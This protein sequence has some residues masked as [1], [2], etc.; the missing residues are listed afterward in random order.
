MADELALSLAQAIAVAN[1]RAGEAGTDV[2]QSLITITQRFDDDGL[3]W[4]INYGPRE[5]LNRRG[6]DLIVD[7]DTRDWTVARVLRGQ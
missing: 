1:Q 5:Y 3:V 2:E 7:I 4:R 6:G